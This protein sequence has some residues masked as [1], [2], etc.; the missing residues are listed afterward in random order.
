M[1]LITCTECGKEFS[2]KA[3]ACPNC[4]CP[5]SKVNNTSSG[6]TRKFNTNLGVIIA[7]EN[8]VELIPAN[9]RSLG[10]TNRTL[11]YKNISGISYL[12]TSLFRQGYIQF[13]TPGTEVQKVN[14]L[15]NG[16]E[17][18]LSRDENTIMIAYSGN[19][20]FKQSCDDFVDFLK[21][22]IG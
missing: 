15:K 19:K 5:T 4:G 20:K 17:K 21:S 14:I 22:K 13:V 3:P 8:Y 6:E 16:W 9:L 11:Y 7:H 18:E 12:P 2:D 10:R 1:A